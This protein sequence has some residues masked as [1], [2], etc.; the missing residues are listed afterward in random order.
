[1]VDAREYHDRT[2]HTPA[3][4]RDPDPRRMDPDIRPRSFKAYVDLPRVDLDGIA[5]PRQP[6][7]AAIARQTAGGNETASRRLDRRTVAT[8]CYLAAGITQEVEQRGQTHRFRAASCTGN[9]H[10]ID[11]YLVCGELPGLPAGVYHFE[12][13]AFALDRLRDGDYRGVIADATGDWALA[14]DAP[15]TAV[16]TSTWWRNAWKYGERTYRHAFWDGGTVMANLLAT[17]HALDYRAAAGCGFVDDALAE[18]LGIDPADE[19]PIATAPIGR[20]AR[21]TDPPPVDPIGPETAPLSPDQLEDP[22]IADA[23]D[24]SVLDDPAAVRAW[25]REATAS[26]LREASPVVS[27][28][29][30][31]MRPVDAETATARPLLE[32]VRRRGSKRDFADAG[33]TRRQLDTVLDRAIRGIPGD[34]NDGDADGP[35]T[36]ELFVLL[37][38]VDGM[39]DGRYW[40]DVDEGALVRFGD[41]DV[42][43]KRQLA[44]NQA[45]AGEAHVNVYCMADVDAV[46]ERLGNRGYRLAQFEAGITLGRLYLSAAAHRR[47]GGTGLTFF[48]RNVAKYLDP[49]DDRNL[50]PM[51]LFAWGRVAPDD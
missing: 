28:T 35:S 47:L 34:W 26:D 13:T 27:G 38:G 17:A 2:D 44:L 14:G 3:R 25:R 18:L 51:T 9:L 41:T 46:V 20:G 30:H 22:L 11:L 43:T 31:E 23:W 37:T 12:P 1:M 36:L 33:P 7:L 29:W 15:I 10:H 50:V 16:L 40:L 19:A 6:A 21:P 45:W 5:P 49:G 42:E 32:T 4:V 24:Q 48:D 39:P 8:V